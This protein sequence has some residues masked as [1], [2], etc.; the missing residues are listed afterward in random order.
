[1]Y[2]RSSKRLKSYTKP[3]TVWLQP[4]SD[5]GMASELVRPPDLAVAGSLGRSQILRLSCPDAA[6]IVATVT[7]ALAGHGALITEAQHYREPVSNSTVLRIVFESDTEAGVRLATNPVQIRNGA[8]HILDYKPGANSEKPIAQLMTLRA[9][10]LT[11]HRPA[12]LRLRLCMVRREPL[13]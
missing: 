11:P 6:G 3:M 9:R 10:A 1:M 12:A 4:K 13:L 8:I 2:D 7:S 5:A